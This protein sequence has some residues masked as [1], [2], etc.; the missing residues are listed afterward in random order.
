MSEVEPAACTP[1]EQAV[2]SSLGGCVAPGGGT[3]WVLLEYS[4][5]RTRYEYAAVLIARVL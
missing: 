5:S 3:A 2:L 4:Y 1:A